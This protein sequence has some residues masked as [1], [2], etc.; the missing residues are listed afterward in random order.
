MSGLRQPQ[1]GADP[2]HSVTLRRGI[3]VLDSGR[4][5]AGKAVLPFTD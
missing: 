2:H 1:I 5:I 3:A 4:S